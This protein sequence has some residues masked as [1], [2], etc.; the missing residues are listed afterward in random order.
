MKKT[1][2]KIYFWF[3]FHLFFDDFCIFL[4][5]CLVLFL[6]MLAG[7]KS[8]KTTENTVVRYIDSTVISYR[9]SIIE[10]E[11][12]REKI[13]DIVAW[14]D[15]LKMQNSLAQAQAY[16]DTNLHVLKGSLETKP[17]AVL[18]KT[19][20]LPSEERIVYRDSITE[21]KIPVKVEVVKYKTPRWA[22]WSI[23][24]FASALAF[25]FR[26]QLL[27]LAKYIVALF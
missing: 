8:P 11:V 27:R 24:G 19:V 15:T 13:V 10:I 17:D 18:T 12:P 4:F 6:L 5:F 1:L 3:K 25:I 7:C 9:D 23:I 14:Y 16:V 2:Q 26:K 21:K 22:Y 20:Y